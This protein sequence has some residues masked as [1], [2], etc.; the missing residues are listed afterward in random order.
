MNQNRS[1]FC[2]YYYNEEQCPYR[3][4]YKGRVWIAEKLASERANASAVDFLTFVA[5]HVS[6][7]DPYGF[8]A[9]VVKYIAEFRWCSI[10]EKMELARVYGLDEEFLFQRPEGTTVF[11]FISVGGYCCTTSGY[12]LYS[13]GR[14]YS[15][16]GGR[17]E[18][19]CLYAHEGGSK[20]L[21][22]QVEAF[23]RENWE[24][25]QKLPEETTNVGCCDGSSQYCKF[26]DKRSHGYMMSLSEDG[27]EVLSY[28]KKIEGFLLDSLGFSG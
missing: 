27:K 9:K 21:L 13:D 12:L 16:H 18:D 25:I 6:K 26:L 4:N 22:E 24:A 20:T 3:D 15:I 8:A 28:A 7:W 2:L 14:V 11:E 5:A 10:E 23:I 1:H 17:P 19:G